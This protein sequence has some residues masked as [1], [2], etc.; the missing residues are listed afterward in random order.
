VTERI[1]KLRPVDNLA[2]NLAT[3][4]LHYIQ[5]ISN[6]SPLELSRVIDELFK[7]QLDLQLV[8]SIE[9]CVE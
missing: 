2:A 6:N 9:T 1:V 8:L 5:L 7:S 4:L 3:Q